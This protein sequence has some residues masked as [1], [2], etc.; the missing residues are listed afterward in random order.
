MCKKAKNRKQ[1]KKLSRI[2]RKSKAK[3]TDKVGITVTNVDVLKIDYKDMMILTVAMIPFFMAL[4][5]VLGIKT[6][7]LKALTEMSYAFT[8]APIIS[9][10]IIIPSIYLTIFYLKNKEAIHRK[11]FLKV[12]LAT[13]SIVLVLLEIRRHLSKLIL[14]NVQGYAL[15]VAV[16]LAI[17]IYY[18]IKMKKVIKF[19]YVR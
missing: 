11:N 2:A 15:I 19:R 1:I 14:F 18:F 6:F 5:C 13:V 4:N 17:I 3:T 9:A 7:N 12:V 8:L 16:A 10:V